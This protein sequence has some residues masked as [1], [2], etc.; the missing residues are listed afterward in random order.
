M[1]Y[2]NWYTASSP[3]TVNAAHFGKGDRGDEGTVIKNGRA[4]VNQRRDGPEDA[5]LASRNG[6]LFTGQ[7]ENGE[8]S[9]IPA[10]LDIER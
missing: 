7:V 9:S 3:K 6:T 5:D 4:V 8:S 2:A 1:S 10:A